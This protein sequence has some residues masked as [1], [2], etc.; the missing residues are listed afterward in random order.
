M[1]VTQTAA[2]GPDMLLIL[3]LTVVALFVAVAFIG[4]LIYFYPYFKNLYK[5]REREK[6]SLGFILLQITVPKANEVKIDAAEQFISALY[7][8]KVGAGG[9]LGLFKDLKPQ[10]HIAFEIVALPE[11]IRFFIAS[12]KK[13]Q[14]FV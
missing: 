1:E 11:S 7:S 10:P 8:I 4:F 13:Y 12:H 3:I 5:Y 6:Y 9:F 2:Q 14:D